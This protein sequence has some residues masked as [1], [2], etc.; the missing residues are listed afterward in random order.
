MVQG[1]ICQGKYLI[2]GMNITVLIVKGMIFQVISKG[3]IVN[4]INVQW[5][6]VEVINFQVMDFHGMIV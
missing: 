2:Q 5:Y 6:I 3:V 4:V 1:I